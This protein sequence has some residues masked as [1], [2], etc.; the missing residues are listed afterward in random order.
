MRFPFNK[1]GCMVYVPLGYCG[2]SINSV[3]D[4]I[5]KVET[6]KKWRKIINSE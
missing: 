3:Q 4:F 2:K 1:D 6:I 5:T